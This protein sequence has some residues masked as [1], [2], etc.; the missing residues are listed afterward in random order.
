MKKR[1]LAF[2]LLLW[3][4]DVRAQVV[5]DV[6]HCSDGLAYNYVDGHQMI[7]CKVNGCVMHFRL[8][9]GKNVTISD[10]AL[11]NLMH[12]EYVSENDIT[13][14]LSYD[15]KGKLN[16]G[17]VMLKRL[18]LSNGLLLRNIEA[19]VVPTQKEDLVVG[20]KFLETLAQVQLDEDGNVI[21]IYALPII[22]KDM[23][24]KEEVYYVGELHQKP[25]FPGGKD[26]LLQWLCQNVHYPEF[27]KNNK[28]E[29]TVIVQFIIEKD[30]LIT[31]VEIKQEVHP[32]LDAE[33]L[34]VISAM[35]NLI[36]GI[37][38][39][40]PERVRIF[41]PFTFKLD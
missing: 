37:K 7:S 35:P 34:R 18:R 6:L 24:V 32:L 27:A 2:F 36:P 19:E 16:G 33:A 25:S 13:N 1:L 17:W 9:K 29:G 8:S 38:N 21:S 15:S 12:L 41:Q 10:S 23:L 4:Y 5:Y 3:L 14:K 39:G 30:G 20:E 40:K 22:K 26:A 31:N 28:I 11:V